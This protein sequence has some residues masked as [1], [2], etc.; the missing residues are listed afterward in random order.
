[1]LHIRGLDPPDAWRQLAVLAAAPAVEGV[2]YSPGMTVDLGS[3]IGAGARCSAGVIVTS[4]IAP[5]ATPD[6]PVEVFQVLPATSTEIAWTRVH[7]TAA[8]LDRWRAQETDLMDLARPAAD[9]S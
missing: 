4:T 2:T 3:P 6:G 7:G 1:M 5:I 8:I 9:L